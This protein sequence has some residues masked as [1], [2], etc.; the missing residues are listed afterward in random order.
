MSK[1]A[2]NWARQQRFSNMALKSLVNAIAARAD[3]KGVT[4]VSQQTLA[5]D[6][7]ATDRYVRQLL[8]IAAELGI[9]SRTPRSAGRKGRLTDLICLSIHRAF[10]L[11]AR[12]IAAARKRRKP[13][14]PTGTRV[15][16]ASQVSNRNKSTLPTGTRVPGNIKGETSYPYQTGNNLEGSGS[17]TS[18]EEALPPADRHPADR[19]DYPSNVIPLLSRGAA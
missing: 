7:G 9:L 18:Q 12:E 5:D 3:D 17:A 10:D 4:W 8:G 1:V 16:V 19:A 11:S 6:M 13:T 2:M 15:P 14:L